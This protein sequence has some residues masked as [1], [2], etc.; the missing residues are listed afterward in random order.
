MPRHNADMASKG[1]KPSGS[2]RNRS[3]IR[4]AQKPLAKRKASPA[5]P[6]AVSAAAATRL[7]KA[8][9]LP[10]AGISVAQ[11]N[12]ESVAAPPAPDE[13]AGSH[14]K[15][16]NG[17]STVNQA[18]VEFPIADDRPPTPHGQAQFMDSTATTTDKATEPHKVL[19]TDQP[20]TLANVESNSAAKAEARATSLL[21]ELDHLDTPVY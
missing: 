13:T 17:Q 9:A 10:A 4:P 14:N 3:S 7:S 18:T 5:A 21:E 12:L 16:G 15:S 20:M 19:Q 2:E 8:A 11:L 6:S 1:R